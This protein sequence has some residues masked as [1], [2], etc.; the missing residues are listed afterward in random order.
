MVQVWFQ[1]FSSVSVAR[2]EVPFSK[3]KTCFYLRVCVFVCVCVF[4]CAGIETLARSKGEFL[5][6]ASFAQQSLSWAF[7]EVYPS[8]LYH[9]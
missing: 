7:A 9:S 6:P 4:A 3:K 8:T 5:N 1:E 2:F